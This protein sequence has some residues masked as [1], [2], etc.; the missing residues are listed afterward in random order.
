VTSKKRR[1]PWLLAALL[2]LVFVGW[3]TSEGENWHTGLGRE[4]VKFPRAMR[5]SDSQ[6]LESRRRA[7][8][9]LLAGGGKEQRDVDPFDV[10]LSAAASEDAVVFIE[11][12][13]LLDSSIGQLLADCLDAD[14]DAQKFIDEM[15]VDPVVDIER[16]ALSGNTVV[17][18]G[19]LSG[20]KRDAVGE[21]GKTSHVGGQ[22]E[23]FDQ[24]EVSM[25][26]WSDE[27]AIISKD[28]SN[29]LGAID[30]IEGRAPFEKGPLP[31]EQRYG[32]IYGRL[33]VSKLLA[34]LSDADADFVSKLRDA[35]EDA[36]FHV[37]LSDGAA[38]VA[39]LRG[40]DEQTM[41]ALARTLGGALSLLR[42]K[43]ATEGEKELAELL[44]SAKVLPQ[45]TSFTVEVA[46]PFEI[47]EQ[48]LR[49]CAK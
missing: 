4:R 21:S 41:N 34:M 39:E 24:D 5:E 38:L 25:G 11:A 17:V 32:H 45:G 15:G 14:T 46:L 49:N 20:L 8:G 7:L 1:W 31:E 43:A 36:S 16:I 2:L 30:R 3:L 22:G 48:A 47:V 23:I 28:R 35:V 18:G 37:D 10:A 42:I 33:P 6:R 44:D 13:A 40:K 19:D 12:R 9:L 27:L 26:L 29:I